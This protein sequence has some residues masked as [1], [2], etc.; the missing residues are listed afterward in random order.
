VPTFA[1]LGYPRLDLLGWFGMLMP[2]ETPKPIV[3]KMSRGI[4][5]ALFEPAT[6]SAVIEMGLVPVAS[7]PAQFA[8]TIARDFPRWQQ[9]IKESGAKPAQQ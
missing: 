2:A 8:E 3:E 6:K 7:T 9:L 1:E 4:H 5:D